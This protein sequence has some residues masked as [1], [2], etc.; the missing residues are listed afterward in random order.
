MAHDLS[1]WPSALNAL[2]IVV[3]PIWFGLND[4]FVA[5]LVIGAVL[6]RRDGRIVLAGVLLGLATL[7]KYYPALLIPF[8]ALDDAHASTRA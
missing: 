5:A 4:G 8:F 7:D 2:P 1:R 3:A 6:A